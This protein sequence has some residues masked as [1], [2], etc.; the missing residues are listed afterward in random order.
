MRTHHLS[1]KKSASKDRFTYASTLSTQVGLITS[2]SLMIYFLAM[3][4]FNLHEILLL[5]YFNF[6]FLLSGI[7]IVFHQFN[8]R[9]GKKGIDY[10]TGLGL[11]I[12]ITLSAV[13]PFAFFMGI[14]LSVDEAFMTFVKNTAEFGSYLNP[15]VAA[16]AV[17][18]EG[19]S[20]GVIT[21]F[22]TM[23]Y[24]KEK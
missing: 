1:E 12:R 9:N 6:I 18:I 13:I 21:T 4:L 23:Q 15:V 14:Y 17:C 24:Y 8:K 20:A 16:G 10:F 5:R 2:L 3:R 22:V 19:I 7:L 11:G